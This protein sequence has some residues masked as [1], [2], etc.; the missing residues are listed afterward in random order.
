MLNKSDFVG[1]FQI[2]EN[3][4]SDITPYINRYEDMILVELMGQ[5]LADDYL[6]DPTDPKWD[7]YEIKD[8]LIGLVYF[9][10]VRDLPYRMTNQ[11]FVYQM[12]E[13]ASQVIHSLALRQRYNESID[14][15]I[16]I[17]RKLK[18]NFEI[19]AGKQRK[20]MID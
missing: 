5:V 7:G 18:D 15:W 3:K 16:K 17:Q 1:K 12:D 4:F 10:Y 11:G 6:S 9:E 8:C 14:L 2:A 13:N 19:F 20:Y